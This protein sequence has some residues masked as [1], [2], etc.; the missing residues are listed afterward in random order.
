M[1]YDAPLG[2]N[3]ITTGTSF[4]TMPLSATTSYYAE[5]RGCPSARAVATVMVDNIGIDVDL[6]PDLTACGGSIAE[7]IPTISNST[8]TK[9]EWQ[10][11]A[12]TSTYDASTTGDYYAT[13]TN[14]NGC[15]D[16]DTVRVTLSPTPTVTDATTNVSCGSAGDGAIDITVTGGTGPYSYTWSNSVTTEDLTGLDGGFYAVTIVDNGTTSACEYVMTYQVTEPIELTANVNSSSIDCDGT[17]GDIDITVTGG[18][19]AYTYLWSTGATTEDVTG[20]PA[21]LQTVTIT[22]ANGCNTTASS[23]ITAANPIVITVDTIYPEVLSTQGGIDITA[24]GGSGVANLRYTWNTG[25]TTDDLTGLVAG[26]YDVTVTDV[27]TGCQQVLTGIVVPYQLPNSIDQLE[28][29]SSFELYPN[30]TSGMV[31]VTMNL[32]KS[33]T[34]Q[35]SVTNIAGQLVQEFAPNEQLEQNYAID[36]SNYPSGVYLA[37]FIIGDQVKTAKIIVE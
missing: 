7:I 37:R 18:T 22:D 25:A 36:L 9:I 31:W 10:D 34:V 14:A 16:T 27:T 2:G 26:T 19:G 21:G 4:T 17:G 12:L 3:L 24:T 11:G 20:A 6:G 30:P 35:L 1:W 32:S 15:T 23:T 29:L 8:A 33:T 13:V 28:D 5:G